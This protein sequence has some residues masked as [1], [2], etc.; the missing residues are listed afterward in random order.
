MSQTL[1]QMR[2]AKTALDEPLFASLPG[3]I[4]VSLSLIHI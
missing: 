3:D 4:D 1:E 2:E